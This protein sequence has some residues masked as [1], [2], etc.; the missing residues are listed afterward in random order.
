M[1]IDL[2]CL[3][4]TQNKIGTIVEYDKNRHSSSGLPSQIAHLLRLDITASLESSTIDHNALLDIILLQ[5]KEYLQSLFISQLEFKF[6]L[7][8]SKVARRRL[9]EQDN[10]LSVVSQSLT[11][12][13]SLVLPLIKIIEMDMTATTVYQLL[14]RT[15][16]SSL[17]DLV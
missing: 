4:W 7:L 2:E 16:G 1:N 8:F 15:H 12:D 13:S 11:R 14:S 9:A 3:I 6:P 17:I 10:S 5:L